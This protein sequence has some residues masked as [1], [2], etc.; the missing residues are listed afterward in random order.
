MLNSHNMIRMVS[1]FNIPISNVVTIS[2]NNRNLYWENKWFDTD[3]PSFFVLSKDGF[4]VV[5]WNL[6]IY[7][8]SLYY[9]NN[10]NSLYVA[11]GNIEIYAGVD[12]KKG[13]GIDSKVSMLEIGYDGKIIDA[14]VYFLSFGITYMYKD[15]KLIFGCNTGLFG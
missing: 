2:K 1:I 13:L 11:A 8:G 4:E 3:R 15:G 7:K 5:G 10:D 12:Y 9:D 6:S 14:N